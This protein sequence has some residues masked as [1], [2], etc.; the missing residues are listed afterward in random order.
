M[1]E[2]EEKELPTQGTET[3][4]KPTKMQRIMSNTS[5][6]G[7]RLRLSISKT[8]VNTKVSAMHRFSHAD[9]T[10]EEPDIVAAL[11][12][13]KSTKRDI[14]AFAQIARRLYDSLQE[15]IQVQTEYESTLQVISQQNSDEFGN[16]LGEMEKVDHDLQRQ[17]K[18]Q[19][20][21]F[22]EK[23]LEPLEHFEFHDIEAS[24]K[25]EIGIQ[26]NQSP[27]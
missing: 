10:Q 1:S 26:T 20:Q 11:R 8:F 4:D 24:E 21:L 22:Q 13:L 5:S 14:T 3:P 25:N 2:I 15:H 7:R 17:R 18:R 27:I 23:V 9:Y 16:F 19:A 6:F 12:L